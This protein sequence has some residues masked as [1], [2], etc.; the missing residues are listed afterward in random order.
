MR[1]CSR[2]K[3]C[4]CKMLTAFLTAGLLAGFPAMALSAREA[5]PAQGQEESWREIPLSAGSALTLT[6]EQKK[7]LEKMK[8]KLDAGEL[9]TNEQIREAISQ[10]E[11]ELEITLTEEQKEQ[12]LGLIQKMNALG[13]NSDE[14]LSKAQELYEKYGEQI[15]KS[16]DAAI[17][18]N[19][20]E[21]VK[22][23]VVE[24][25][26]SAIRD[27]FRDMGESIRSFFCPPVFLMK[28]VSRRLHLSCGKV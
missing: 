19:I 26:K 4:T 6:E 9:E 10:C 8:E 3:K 18:E 28:T 21:P 12:L 2:L 5:I 16:A 1:K 20:V 7:L 22:E 27:F 23:A 17:Q 15:K 14:M 25:T 13:L 24:G 11:E